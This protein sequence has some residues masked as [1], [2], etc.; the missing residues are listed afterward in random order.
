VTWEEHIRHR[1]GFVGALRFAVILIE[2]I[3]CVGGGLLIDVPSEGRLSARKFRSHSFLL[4]VHF[5]G[6]NALP[7]AGQAVHIQQRKAGL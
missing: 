7:R 1:C 4:L 3:R 5:A 6:L 2:L